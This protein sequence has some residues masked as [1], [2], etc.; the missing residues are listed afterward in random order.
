MGMQRAGSKAGAGVLTVDG[1]RDAKFLVCDLSG[2]IS[3][4]PVVG[5]GTV[6][7]VRFGTH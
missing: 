3:V 7:P 6:S 1:L 2:R 4:S 5:L